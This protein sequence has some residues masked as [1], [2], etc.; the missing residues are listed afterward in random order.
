MKHLIPL[1]CLAVAAPALASTRY[2][3]LNN[4]TPAPPFT[5]WNTAWQWINVHHAEM[6]LVTLVK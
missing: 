3:N 6:S 1:L 5:T 4:P 2:V